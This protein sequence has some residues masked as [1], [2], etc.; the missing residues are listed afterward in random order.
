[1]LDAA[2]QFLAAHARVLDRRRFERL[3]EGGPPEPVRDAV[4]AH[5]NADGGF[6]HALEPDGRAPGS[7]PA[8][9]MLALRTLH[10]AGAWD[11][12]LV[13]GACDWLASVEPDGGGVAVRAA[14]DRGLA[15][16]AVVGAP[17]RAPGV[18]DDD[19]PDRRH[20]ARAR[21]RAPVGRARRRLA[22]DGGRRRRAGVRPARGGRFLGA[23]PD[24]ERARRGPAGLAPR[25]DGVLSPAGRR[26]P[27]RSRA[28]ELY[29]PEAV[30]ADLDRLAAGQAGDG[31]W[32]FA[33]PAW[34]P[35]AEA[36]WRGSITV[37]ALALLRA[38]GR[39]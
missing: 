20:A 1:M 24:H 8:A 13:A 36:D 17:A 16:G 18:A 6:G 31:G 23:A 9:V 32:T 15:G 19:R 30:A 35:A 39:A 34:S 5:R 3:F 27:A 38:N 4:A 14:V 12:G 22:V 26:A 37:D 28:R 2:K 10:E 11:A 7:Q 25:L 21:R 29:A 33:W